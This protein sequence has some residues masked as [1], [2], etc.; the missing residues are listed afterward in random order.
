MK[1]RWGKM[2]SLGILRTRW[3]G[4]FWMFCTLL[5]YWWMKLMWW[6]SKIVKHT[7]LE[8]W[9]FM[10]RWQSSVTQGVRHGNRCTVYNRRVWEG[11]KESLRLSARGYNHCLG[12]VIVEFKFVYCH[13]GFYIINTP[14]WRGGNLWFDQGVQISGVESRQHVSG[15]AQTAFQWQWK[16]CCLKIK[17]YR[18][19]DWSLQNTEWD[20]NWFR[21]VEIDTDRLSV[22]CKVGW[23][24][25][26][27]HALYSEIM[28]K[29][30]E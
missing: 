5:G 23:K 29:L 18:S 11:R 19:K 12:L 14:A 26:Q 22:V 27:G 4:F 13:P 10:I 25:L 21:G 9:V 28:V 2:S 6:S 30:M 16:R 3:A 7:R 20:G 1:E 17:Q 8:M 24:P 15:E